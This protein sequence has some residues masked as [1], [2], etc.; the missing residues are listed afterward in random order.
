MLTN[1]EQWIIIPRKLVYLALH[2]TIGKCKYTK[3]IEA[4]NPRS[5]RDLRLFQLPSGDVRPLFVIP[6]CRPGS[7]V[8]AIA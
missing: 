2:F 5:P 1:L 8:G 3:I 6:S 4:D 7:H